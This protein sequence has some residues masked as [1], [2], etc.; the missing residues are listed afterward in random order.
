MATTNMFYSHECIFH[1]KKLGEI[2]NFKVFLVVYKSL[3]LSTTGTI[4]SISWSLPPKR[5]LPKFQHV[6]IR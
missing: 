5:K 3:V 6:T 1:R 4:S 2:N